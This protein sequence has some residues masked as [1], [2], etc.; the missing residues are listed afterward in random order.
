[1]PL[2]NLISLE[3]TDEE[4]KE[5]DTS[6]KVLEKY[7]NKKMINL[8]PEEKRKYGRP[9]P[10]FMP[11]IKKILMY[12]EQIPELTPNYLKTGEF[13]KDVRSAEFLTSIK[14]RI[15]LLNES[16]DD[17]TILIRKDIHQAGFI[18]YRNVKLAA[19]SDVPGSTSVY[20]DLKSIFTSRKARK[21]ALE[22]YKEEKII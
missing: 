7:F 17:T 2:D 16:V 5:I 6:L 12:M 4:V 14:A 19:G 8:T 3:F 1:M 15:K 11:W 22:D 18:Y 10:K 13:K 9:G 20:Q 21:R